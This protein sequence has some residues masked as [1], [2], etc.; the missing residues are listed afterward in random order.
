MQKKS[1]K[2]P[3]FKVQEN[4]IQRAYIESQVIFKFLHMFSMYVDI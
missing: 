1:I 3:F 4:R 2:E